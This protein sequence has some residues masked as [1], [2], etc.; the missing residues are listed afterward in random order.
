VVI[1]TRR[2]ANERGWLCRKCRKRF[3]RQFHG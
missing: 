3:V 1:F 2:G